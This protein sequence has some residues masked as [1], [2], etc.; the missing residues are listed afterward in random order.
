MCHVTEAQ[1]PDHVLSN[2]EEQ[3]PWDLFLIADTENLRAGPR[4]SFLDEVLPE[5]LEDFE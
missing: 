4:L 1:L 3:A 5:D 2:I